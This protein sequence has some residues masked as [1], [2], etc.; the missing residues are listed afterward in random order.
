MVKRSP[1]I[2][3]RHDIS[4]L[5]KEVKLACLKQ[6]IQDWPSVGEERKPLITAPTML[7][8]AAAYLSIDSDGEKK[9]FTSK[10]FLDYFGENGYRKPANI[11]ALLVSHS[12]KR[13]AFFA[14][15]E[16]GFEITDAG[17]QK[18]FK[19]ILPFSK[20]YSKVQY[21]QGEEPAAA[22]A[23]PTASMLEKV[24][25]ERIDLLVFLSDRRNAS[26]LNPQVRVLSSFILDEL[27]LEI[28]LRR[29]QNYQPREEKIIDGICWH[30]MQSVEDTL[31]RTEEKQK[32]NSDVIGTLLAESLL[33]KSEI[34]GAE[35]ISVTQNGRDLVENAIADLGKS[36]LVMRALGYLG[37]RSAKTSLV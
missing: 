30:T 33:E 11:P 28:D 12:S 27:N 26:F 3:E 8:L 14:R 6:V 17:E 35:H 1:K 9:V 24:E 37:R 31:L 36:A 13:K 20:K 10:D 4:H 7:L 15:V 34:Q 23:S 32:L 19:G 21:Q 22:A 2:E 29:N 16:G 18:Y 25:G 5:S